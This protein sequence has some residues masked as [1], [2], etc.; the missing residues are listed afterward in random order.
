[1]REKEKEREREREREGKRN[2]FTQHGGEYSY[3]PYK[4]AFLY[5]IQHTAYPANV[6][7]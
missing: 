6:L 4:P 1:M 7:I 5:S 2:V 3:T